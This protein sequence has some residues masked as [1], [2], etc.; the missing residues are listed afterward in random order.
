[1]AADWGQVALIASAAIPSIILH[2]VAHGAAAYALGDD[3]AKRAGRLTLN[4]VAHIDPMGT[5]IVPLLLALSGAGAFGWAKPVPV[6]TRRLRKPRRD[7]LLVSLAGPATNLGLAVGATLLLRAF[8]R[9]QLHDPFGHLSLPAELLVWIAFMNVL[10]AVFNML[11]I[12]PLDGSALVERVLPNDWRPAW[13]RFRNYGLVVLM[14][15]VFM[16]P[17]GLARVVDPAVRLW[18]SFL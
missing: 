5:V 14:A 8:Y 6:N 15:L 10:L 18:E 12:P 2:E 17:G 11:P 3:T 7:S 1:M 9:S 13:D 4:P 16:V